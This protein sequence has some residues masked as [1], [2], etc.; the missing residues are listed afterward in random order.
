MQKSNRE[1]S[2]MLVL[3]SY[4]EDIDIS[5]KTIERLYDDDRINIVLFN[6]NSLINKTLNLTSA[7]AAGDGTGYMLSI[8]EHYASVA[9]KLKDK[10]KVNTKKRKKF[11]SFTLLDVVKRIYLAYGVSYKSEKDA[12]NKAMEMLTKTKILLT[13]IRLDRYYSGQKLVKNLSETH[14]GIKFYLIPKKNSTIKGS[15]AW[16]K[17]LTLFC[18]DFKNYC[19]EYY[20]R[21]QSESGFSEDKRRFGWR[22]PQKIERR[23]NTSYFSIFTWHNLLWMG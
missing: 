12:Y 11:Y 17:M 14:E 21:N 23:I 15:F 7:D 8:K 2:E 6:M 22:I 3:F 16:K 13:S 9:Q 4:L 10:G 5:Y 1:M 19:S 20:K 18:N